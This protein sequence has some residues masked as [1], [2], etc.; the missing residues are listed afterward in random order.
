M[1]LPFFANALFW[2]KGDNLDLK[3]PAN[4]CKQVA[5]SAGVQGKSKLCR[6]LEVARRP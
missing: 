4:S 2:A 5:F 3:H 1:Q 6:A